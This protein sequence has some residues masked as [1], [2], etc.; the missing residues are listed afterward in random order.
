MAIQ[1]GDGSSSNNGRQISSHYASY[2]TRLATTSS[3]GV[4][5]L[6][7]DVT[8]KSTNSRMLITASLAWCANNN[9]GYINIRRDN[10]SIE[11]SSGTTSRTNSH[12]GSHY[13]R[14]QYDISR[15]TCVLRDHPNTTNQ[16]TYQVLVYLSGGSNGT[17]FVNRNGYDN[18]RQYDPE[19]ISFL[20]VEEFAP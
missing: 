20:I 3:S 4:N 18:N 19:G 2:D 12:F 13:D 14:G 11:T 17:L 15:E 16:V 8:P 6:T 9:D 10:N 5:I 7:I 1:Y